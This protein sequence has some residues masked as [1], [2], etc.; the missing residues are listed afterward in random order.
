MAEHG[1]AREPPPPA[2]SCPNCGTLTQKELN[3]FY[4]QALA[5]HRILLACPACN[6]IG[7]EPTPP[8]MNT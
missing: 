3:P 2:R 1:P 5:V 4:G 6:W 7:F 8:R